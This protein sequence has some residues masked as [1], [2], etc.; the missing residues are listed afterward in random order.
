MS[1]AVRLLFLYTFMAC[2]RTTLLLKEP[3]I[4]GCNYELCSKIKQLI[5]GVY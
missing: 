3:V 5:Y 1:G 2:I 4:S